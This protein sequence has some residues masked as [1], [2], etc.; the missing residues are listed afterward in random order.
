MASYPRAR[1]QLDGLVRAEHMVVNALEDAAARTLGIE[2]PRTIVPARH[3]ER[4]HGAG[5]GIA[6]VGPAAIA[7]GIMASFAPDE[8]QHL[9]RTSHALLTYCI[10]G[11]QHRAE[12][13]VGHVGPLPA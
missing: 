13:A 11:A 7:L 9:L 10:R 5:I 12:E 1:A 6:E 3:Q 2:A 8:R 4:R